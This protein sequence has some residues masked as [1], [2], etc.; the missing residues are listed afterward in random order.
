MYILEVYATP[1]PKSA[2]AWLIYVKQA[3]ILG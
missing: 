2:K 1:H 3:I